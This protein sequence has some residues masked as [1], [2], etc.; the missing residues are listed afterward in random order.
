MG[1]N[2][3]VSGN[4][5]YAENRET[6]GLIDGSAQS[7]VFKKRKGSDNHYALYQDGKEQ[8]LKE[9]FT[10]GEMYK[11][12]KTTLFTANEFETF[13]EENTGKSSPGA[14]GGELFVSKSEDE[15]KI[16]DNTLANDPEI[17][18]A[19]KSGKRYALVFQ[20][21]YEAHSSAD[22]RHSFTFPSG[23]IFNVAINSSTQQD[24]L[25]PAS[26]TESS[27]INSI[28]TTGTNKG[29]E[30]S[31]VFIPSADGFLRL[32]WAQ[33]TADINASILKKGTFLRLKTD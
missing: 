15:S 32:K 7:T 11:E 8:A 25:P 1:W 33:Q 2:I 23:S 9:K 14:A 17:F 24:F 26:L 31:G 10:I 20:A 6:G 5:L 18:L 3:W 27:I 16:S 22:F 30:W 28:G 21:V 29:V 12:D 19:V 4:Y 13:K